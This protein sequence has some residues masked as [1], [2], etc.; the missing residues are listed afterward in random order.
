LYY[1]WRKKSIL[2]SVEKSIFTGMI[3]AYI[4]HNIFVFDNLISYI[5]FFSLLA[6]IHSVST[7][8]KNVGGAFYTKLFSDN[9]S[10][11]AVLPVVSVITILFVY[12]VN[13]PAILANQTLIQSITPQKEGIERNLTLFKQVFS[14]NSFGSTEA[15]EQ[16][17]TLT[18]Q[19]ASLSQ[20]PDNIKNDFYNFAKEKIEQKISKTPTDARYLVF[21][22]SFFNR[23]G[24]YDLGIQYLERALIE[25]PKKQSI[26]FEL[27][28]SYANK[29]DYTKT[30]E[31]FKQ[32][33][34][35]KPE[36]MESKTIYALG[37]IYTKN[38]QVLNQIMSQIDKNIIISD[39]RFLKA[40]A[41][42]GDYSTVVLILSERLTK[43]PTN[44]QT[45]LSLAS[46][47]TSLGQKQ[48]AINLI[49]EI[50]AVNSDFKKQGE[51]YIKEIQGQ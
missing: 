45:K 31:L 19:I 28:S 13:V 41:D 32:A 46:A 2:T 50:I 6:F 12:F 37:A 20:V 43:D 22:G 47:Y 39:N 24:Q 48:K 3:S 5:I 51:Q 9:V 38:I 26:Y 21:A 25:S 10:I 30:F 11:Y 18:S 17:L 16:L 42:I 15:I 4:F 27:G 8:D 49:R 34:D 7:E 33:Y 44:T 40:Y 29:N 36:S 23:F 1:V 14:Y 35:L